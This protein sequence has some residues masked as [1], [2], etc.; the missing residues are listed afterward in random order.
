[1]DSAPRRP[2]DSGSENWIVMKSVVMAGLIRRK[3][4]SIWEPV[5]LSS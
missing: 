5:S 2:R 1:M 3:E 4:R